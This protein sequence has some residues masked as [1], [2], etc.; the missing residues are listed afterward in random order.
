MK[1]GSYL[2]FFI[3]LAS[4]AFCQKITMVKSFGGI[5]FEM[6]TLTLSPRQVLNL[7]K[8][9]PIAYDEFSRARS[10]YSASGVLGFAGG[11]MIAI[12]LGTLIA[13]GNPE[14]GFAAGGAALILASVPFNNAFHR[15]AHRAVDEYN[16]KFTSFRIKTR[17]YFT[18]A[19]AKV[20]IRF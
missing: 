6:D 4:S 17:Y 15:H 9:T 2:L 3:C 5:R 7:M 12:P 11:L 1:T 14:W 20:V 16:K 10:N 8:D 18:G 19:G 13:G